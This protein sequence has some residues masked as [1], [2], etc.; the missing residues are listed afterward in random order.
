MS[1]TYLWHLWPSRRFPAS[2]AEEVATIADLTTR[3]NRPASTF[4]RGDL[5]GLLNM[6]RLGMSVT[7]VWRYAPGFEADRLL[8]AYHFIESRRAESA[9][10]FALMLADPLRSDL[11]ELAEL[12]SPLVPVPTY[13]IVSAVRAYEEGAS[14]AERAEELELAISLIE[15]TCAA[16]ISQARALEENLV[17]IASRDPEAAVKVARRLYDPYDVCLWADPFYIPRRVTDLLP[18]RVSD[19]LN[20]DET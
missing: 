10:S 20:E 11:N 1:E 17:L 12:A 19:L 15:T 7:E 8:A 4:E 14:N 16:A 5:T 6:L 2:A 18:S 9:Q 13:R 3:A